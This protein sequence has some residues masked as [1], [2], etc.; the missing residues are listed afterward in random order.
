MS[1]IT[2]ISRH[3]WS[4]I[5]GGISVVHVLTIYEVVDYYYRRGVWNPESTSLKVAVELGWLHICS[6][7]VAAFIAG[8]AISI[9]RPWTYGAIAL[10]LAL[11]SFFFYVG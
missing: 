2:Q 1:A 8:V 3:K 10:V 5:S 6:I 9:E 7:L 11:F 4:A